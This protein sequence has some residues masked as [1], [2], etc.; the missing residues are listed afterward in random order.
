MTLLTILIALIALLLI[1]VVMVQNPKGGGLNSAFGGTQE[2]QKI[3]GASRSGDILVKVTWTLGGLLM[4]LTL[5][6][7][8]IV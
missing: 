2:A 3:M 6:A 7:G 5:L 4:L 1:L 8:L